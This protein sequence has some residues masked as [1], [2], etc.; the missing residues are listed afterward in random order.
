[1]ITQSSHVFEL[2]PFVELCVPQVMTLAKHV[3]TQGRPLLCGGCKVVTPNTAV[4]WAGEIIGREAVL[5]SA[6][7]RGTTI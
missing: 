2:P 6:V 3:Q 1:M 5:G 4:L 7:L